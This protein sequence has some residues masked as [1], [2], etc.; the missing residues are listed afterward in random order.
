MVVGCS[1]GVVVTMV[2][3]FVVAVRHCCC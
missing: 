2:F 3:V 1:L